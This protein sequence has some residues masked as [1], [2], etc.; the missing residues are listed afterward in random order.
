M[1]ASEFRELSGMAEFRAA[2]ALQAAVWGK[3]DTPDSAELMMA[4]QAEGGFAA[5]AFVDGRLIGYVFGSP[6]ATPGIQDS[7]RLAV[8]P[9]MR[10]RGLGAALK[11]YQRR[12]CLARSIRHVRWTF[13]PLRAVNAA[14]N[15]DRLGGRSTTYLV[16]YYGAMGGI[17]EGLPSDRLLVDWYLDDPII[18]AKSEGRFVAEK[19]K[20]CLR[21]RI[22]PDVETLMRHDRVKALG[23]RVALRDSLCEAFAGDYVINGFD[24]FE[25]AYI[26]S[27]KVTP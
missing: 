25:R 6:S 24:C 27:R 18:T 15:I 5:G 2:E 14:L 10:G 22:P 13:D 11:W 26:L 23:T 7:Q 20:G 1:S 21:I 4:I 17:N 8:L 3:G 12:W 16:D 9:E 19:A